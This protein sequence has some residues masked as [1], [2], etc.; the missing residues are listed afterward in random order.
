MHLIENLPEQ[1]HFE[2]IGKLLERSTEVSIASPFLMQDFGNFFSEFD[3]SRLKKVN[4]LTTLKPNNP[5]QI[6]KINTLVSFLDLKENLLTNVVAEIKIDNRLH[7]KVYLFKSDNEYI[8][9]VVTS[10]NFTDSGLSRNNELGILFTDA[11]VIKS[12][13]EKYFDNPK[14]LLLSEDFILK[15]LY[16]IDEYLENNPKEIPPKFDLNLND[17][18]DTSEKIPDFGTYKNIWLK[19]IGVSENPFPD[20]PITE[21]NGRLDFSKRRPTGVKLGDLLITFAVGKRK[22]MS[23]YRATGQ[24]HFATKEEIALPGH[25][26]RERW[27]WSI[28]GEN[29]TTEFS[30]NWWN[31]NLTIDALREEYLNKF[32]ERPISA[33]GGKTFGTFQYKADKM[34]VTKEFGEFILDKISKNNN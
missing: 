16:A 4:L 20:E 15:S 5:E 14:H 34:R 3:C 18:L 31:E 13:E 11:E 29:L 21:L 2:V 9:G 10:A 27:P 12:L 24:P 33:A 26:H 30:K 1:N 7:A 6:K 25:G 17:L 19:P 32:P 8:G 23:V 22:I 28:T